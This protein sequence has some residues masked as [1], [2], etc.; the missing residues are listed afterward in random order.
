MIIE[1]N[2]F[3]SGNT[4]EKDRYRYFEKQEDSQQTVIAIS[5]S[6]YINIFGH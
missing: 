6:S 3:Q 5:Y 1:S 2:C 4:D